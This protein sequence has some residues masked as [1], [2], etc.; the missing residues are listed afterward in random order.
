MRRFLTEALL[1]VVIASVGGFGSALI[2]LERARNSGTLSMGAWV[3]DLRATGASDNP[4][5]AAIAATTLNLPLGTAEGLAFTA[6]VD[7]EG[8]ELS[9]RCDYSIKGRTPS[10]LLWTLSVYDDQDLL[11]ANPASRT[12]FHSREILRDPDG[13]FTVSVSAS[14]QPGNWLPAEAAG[15]IVFVLRLYDTPLTT[16]LS[17]GDEAMP[18][19]IAGRCR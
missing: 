4:Y 6:K 14:V 3:A 15:G 5:S 11:M 9:G 19:I 8:R 7:D 10:A 17:A 2:A 18:A 1:I 13:A 16:G 12:G